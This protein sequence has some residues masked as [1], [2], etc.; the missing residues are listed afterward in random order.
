MVEPA[1]TLVSNQVHFL[2]AQGYTGESPGSSTLSLLSMV[3]FV[4]VY[5][6]VS[7]FSQTGSLHYCKFTLSYKPKCTIF[8]DGLKNETG[9]H[10]S[11]HASPRAVFAE[12]MAVSSQPPFKCF[13]P[14]LERC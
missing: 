12:L 5:F 4:P 13:L 11:M 2:V 8:I 6:L 14:I 1:S 9:Y 7:A 10:A 3:L